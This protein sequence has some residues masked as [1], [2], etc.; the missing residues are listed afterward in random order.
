MQI[1]EALTRNIMNL[2]GSITQ[3]YIEQIGTPLVRGLEMSI[4][5]L[6]I[7]LTN[8]YLIIYLSMKSISETIDPIQITLWLGLISQIIRFSD[9][10]SDGGGVL[11]PLLTRI[12]PYVRDIEEKY[13]LTSSLIL[14]KI[15]ELYGIYLYIYLFIYLSNYLYIYKPN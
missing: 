1:I 12:W 8:I 2:P 3:A 5:Y 11:L 9:S 15:F 6:S 7:Y 14:E 4:R 10:H 13:K